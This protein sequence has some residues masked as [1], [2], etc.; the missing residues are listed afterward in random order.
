MIINNEKK[1]II[2]LLYFHVTGPLYPLFLAN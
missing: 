2:L 1:K